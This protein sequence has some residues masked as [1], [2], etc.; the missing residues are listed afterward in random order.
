MRRNWLRPML[1]TALAVVLG[2]AT[3]IALATT[4]TWRAR[5]QWCGLPVLSGRVVDVTV[6]DM[7]AGMM[8]GMMD[9]RTRPSNDQRWWGTDPMRIFTEPGTVAAGEVSL[10]VHNSGRLIHEVLVLPLAAG[11]VSGARSVGSDAR[12][13]EI[14]SVGEASTTCGADAGTG[15]APHSVSWTTLS[16]TPGHYELVCNLPGHY[17]DGAHVEFDVTSANG[18]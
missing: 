18:K 11:Q 14:G 5:P 17:R 15:I 4:G 9:G 2:I 10:R 3:T 13:D 7:G 1:I 8:P 12:V 16:L 6:T